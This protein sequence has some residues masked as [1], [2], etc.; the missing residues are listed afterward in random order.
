MLPLLQPE[1]RRLP[2]RVRRRVDP[3]PRRALQDRRRRHLAVARPP[4]DVPDA[5]HAARH[6]R[7]SIE[8]HAREF[9]AAMLVLEAG[10]L[11]AFVAL[12]LFLF[13]VFW[14]VMLIPMYLIIG[15]WG[16]QRRLYASIKFVIYTMVGS[17]L[18]L[19]AIFY[20]YVAGT[21]PSLG[22][23]HDRPR[24]AHRRVALP[25]NAQVWCFARV[26]ARVRDQGAAVPAPH[27]V[28]RRARRGA[29]GGLGDPGRRA[30][31][32]R[33]LRLPALRDAAVPAGAA[34][35]APTLA[36]LAVIGIIYG[37]LVA[38]AQDDVKKLVAYSSVSHLG[39]L[40][41]RHL[42]LTAMGVERLDLR[43]AVARH[44]HRRPV[45]RHR[46]ALRAPPHAPARRVRRHLEADAGLRG[47]VPDHHDGLGGPARH[48]PASSASS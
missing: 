3:R 31:E 46:R 36:I 21:T 16:G 25:H 6:A 30:A 22:A 35:W 37:A 32:V 26:R 39:L 27:L 28:A 5:A 15:I 2:A 38:F 13:Y 20:V 42:A 23:L 48:C 17:L 44:H 18:M 45:P 8:K 12:D 14:E 40:H 4:D 47:A 1:G 41:A 7:T 10:M 11:G 29:D 24:A 34:V 9:I 19:V 33:H 43:D